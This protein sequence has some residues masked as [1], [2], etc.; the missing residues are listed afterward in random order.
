MCIVFHMPA[1]S[2]V[3]SI[4]SIVCLNQSSH[5]L[6]MSLA[7]YILLLGIPKVV[8]VS[9]NTDTQ[10]QI[11]IYIYKTSNNIVSEEKFTTS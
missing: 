3:I 4:D 2:V 9:V 1:I 10:K 7:F 8:V 6:L 5:C 11:Y